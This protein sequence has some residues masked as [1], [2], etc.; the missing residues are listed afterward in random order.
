MS[1][2]RPIAAF[3]VVTRD[4]AQHRNQSST[5]GST[6]RLAGLEG[7]ERLCARHA[8]LRRTTS[9]WNSGSSVANAFATLVR[10]RIRS[11]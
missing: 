10:A 5:L 1:R 2:V 4:V 7:L 8:A 6:L 3:S 11:R 9:A